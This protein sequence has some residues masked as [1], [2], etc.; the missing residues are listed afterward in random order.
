MLQDNGIEYSV[1]GFDFRR[2]IGRHTVLGGIAVHGNEVCVLFAEFDNVNT[3]S[4]P[5]SVHKK[6]VVLHV[7]QPAVIHIAR[8]NALPHA[9]NILRRKKPFQH[10]TLEAWRHFAS[11]PFDLGGGVV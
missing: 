1:Q 8:D 9:L 11:F 2:F 7:A 4:R 6:A 5:A 10:H 3:K